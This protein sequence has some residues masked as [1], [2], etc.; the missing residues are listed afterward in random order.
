M[1]GQDE[2]DPERERATEQPMPRPLAN[3]PRTPGATAPE[4]PL[5]AGELD[6]SDCVI[7]ARAGNEQ[8]AR[9]LVDRHPTGLA[10]AKQRANVSSTTPFPTVVLQP[11]PGK[12]RIDPK[13]ELVPMRFKSM[14][15]DAN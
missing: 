2:S 10:A 8:A 1:D 6:D 11:L 7:L 9:E 14:P 3:T 12:Q 4:A 5:R 15:A 13:W